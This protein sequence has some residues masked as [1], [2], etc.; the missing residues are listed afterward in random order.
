MK[1][2]KR[3][4][5]I[6]LAIFAIIFSSCSEDW[7]KPDPLSFYTPENVFVDPAGYEAALV[8]CKKEMNSENHGSYNP[9]VTETDYSDL[10]VALRQSDFTKVTP[11]TSYQLPILDFFVN[12]YGYIKNANTI[13]TRIDDIEWLI[14]TNVTE[15]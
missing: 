7:L 5:I 3:I 14:K 12:A 13:I 8:R 4:Y 11:S 1:S 6:T 10:A 15:F 2:T 9:L